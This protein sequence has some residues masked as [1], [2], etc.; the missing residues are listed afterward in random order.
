MTKTIWIELSKRL[1]P[2]LEGVETEYKYIQTQ[3]GFWDVASCNLYKSSNTTKIWK[4]IKTLNLEEVIE[5]LPS[6]LSEWSNHYE[7]TIKRWTTWISNY[8]VKYVYVFDKHKRNLH[9]ES[10]EWNEPLLIAIEKML[11][12]LLDNNLLK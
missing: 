10:C 5:F 6:T 11:E 9:S 7:M 4:A 1:A 2:Y 8:I 12:Y 3:R